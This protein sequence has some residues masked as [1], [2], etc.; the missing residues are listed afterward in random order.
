MVEFIFIKPHIFLFYRLQKMKKTNF[1]SNRS[2]FGNDYD[3]APGK[4]AR[5]KDKSSK[6]KLSIYDEYEDVDDE[7]IIH[8]KFKNRH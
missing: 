7:Y 5:A 6:R 8:E 2:D 3:S 4:K 1:K